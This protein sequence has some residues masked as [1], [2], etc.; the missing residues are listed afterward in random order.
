MRF[1]TRSRGWRTT[2]VQFGLL[3]VLALAVM[4]DVSPPA[5]ATASCPKESLCGLKKPLV[6]FVLDYSSAMGEPYNPSLTRWDAAVQAITGLVQADNGLLTKHFMLG[7]LR[8]GH[9]PDP[10]Q[11]GTMI[12]GDPTG[13]VDG[14]RLDV[15]P[16]DL[17]DPGHAY[18]ECDHAGPLV[19]ALGNIPPPAPG[20]ARW[21][22]GGLAGAR[23]VLEQAAADHPDDLGER[24]AAVIL[25]TSGAW[26]GPTGGAP[27]TPAS[28]DP[29]VGAAELLADLGV[30][31]H[32]VTL[33]DAIDAA[34]AAELAAAGGTGGP[35]AIECPAEA[36]DTLVALAP[37]LG[38]AI[39][40]GACGEGLPRAMFVLDASSS[41]LNV[42]FVHAPPGLG[43][44]DQARDALAGSNGI[45]VHPVAAAP[46][47]SVEMLAHLGLTVFGGPG[48]AKHAVDYG[49]CHH[50]NFAWAL[51]PVVSCELPGCVDPYALPPIV[52]TFKDGSVGPPYFATPTVS[53]MP[54]CDL[55]VPPQACVGSATYTHL[56]L[57]AVVENLAAYKQSCAQPDAPYPCTDETLF[58]NVL[59][60]DGKYS[61]TDAQVKAPLEQM[62]GDG[63]VTHVIGIGDLV[64]EPSFVA[65][66]EAMAHW[67]SGGQRDAIMAPN[68][69]VLEDALAAIFDEA[70]ASV[71][72]DPCCQDICPLA[73]E[74]PD[75]PDPPPDTT[76]GEFCG[77]E[78]PGTTGETG[79]ETTGSTGDP[80]PETSTEP[81]SGTTDDVTTG[82]GSSGSTGV[83]GATTGIEPAPTTTA[84]TTSSSATSEG[85]GTTGAEEGGD[86]C[87]CTTGGSTSKGTLL[88]LALLLRRRARRPVDARRAG[89]AAVPAHRGLRISQLRHRKARPARSRVFNAWRRS[90]I[91]GARP[92]ASV[93][94][95]RDV[96]ARGEQ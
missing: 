7:A 88:L 92:R 33:G 16:Y 72:L 28:A 93:G 76:W 25:L 94:I 86:G 27:L 46:G 48:E 69:A 40:T 22:R 50:G 4:S 34:H 66:L 71:A 11:S 18:Y 65:S 62:Y 3:T 63:V 45:F 60:T 9:D 85:E 30:P 6:L 84:A 47:L 91:L 21:T 58:F 8:F 24:P 61:S 90:T 1:G 70:L 35:L 59:I 37:V 39:V 32:V 36:S 52:W 73:P 75:D 2:S 38:K 95:R 83:E 87:G 31:T 56:G 81:S 54:R 55:A 41:M 89:T 67:G 82:T 29:A 26:T 23:A 19:Q 77:W 79:D 78:D 12:A 44:W 42:G 43:N 10:D 5:G 64:V 14:V 68:Q 74:P 20:I 53:H 15:A 51:D 80:P 49:P 57:Q 96:C 17:E 13:L